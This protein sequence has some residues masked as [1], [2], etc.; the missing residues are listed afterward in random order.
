MK[1]ELRLRPSH[2]PE[3]R[4]LYLRRKRAGSVVAGRC[5]YCKRPQVVSLW[6]RKSVL[7]RKHQAENR[8]KWGRQQKVLLS[9]DCFRSVPSTTLA[10]IAGLIDGEGH[11]RVGRTGNSRRALYP[12]VIVRMKDREPIDLL[13]SVFGGSQSFLQKVSVWSWQASG[14]RAG[15]VLLAIRPYLRLTRKSKMCSLAIRAARLVG[16]AH[17]WAVARNV[18]LRR[19]INELARELQMIRVDKA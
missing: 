18:R 12:V 16:R 13:F 4:R 3:Y 11:I 10:Y 14:R 5:L 19:G 17:Q 8:K 9:L 6:G 1:S 15:A 2:Q 7:C